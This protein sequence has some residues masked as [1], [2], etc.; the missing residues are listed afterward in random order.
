MKRTGMGGEMERGETETERRPLNFILFFPV[1]SGRVVPCSEEEAWA[2]ARPVRV[3]RL[4][5]M[6]WLFWLLC[7]LPLWLW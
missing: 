7:F 6:V 1:V 4:R 5:N 2:P 3:P